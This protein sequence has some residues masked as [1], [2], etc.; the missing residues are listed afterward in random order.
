MISRK[1]ELIDDLIGYRVKVSK[2][3]TIT[4]WRLLCLFCFFFFLT[5]W[6][7]LIFIDLSRFIV[8]REESHE[9][10]ISN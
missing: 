8:T 7:L 1:N 3:G 9:K 4:F 10:E 6:I 2:G 5:C